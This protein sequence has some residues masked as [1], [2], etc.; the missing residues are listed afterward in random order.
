MLI[1]R[2]EQ[3]M[4][5]MDYRVEIS[6]LRGLAVITANKCISR[7]QCKNAAFKPMRLIY[8]KFK[9]ILQG[10]PNIQ[11]HKA[12]VMKPHLDGVPCLQKE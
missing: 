9:G 8:A 6:L 4:N 7:G 12:I 3:G 5:G 11:A 10:P 1:C 2:E